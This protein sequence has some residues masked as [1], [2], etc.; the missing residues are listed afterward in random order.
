MTTY[1]GTPDPDTFSGTT[2]RDTFLNIGV[3]D[4]VDGKA[5]DDTIAIDLSAATTAVIYNAVAAATA[6]G[7]NL[8]QGLSVRNV[9]FLRALKTGSGNDTLI[10]S[11]AQGPF[12]WDGNGGTDTLR[13]DFSAATEAMRS[14]VT[15]TGFNFRAGQWDTGD[16][17]TA[18]H[19]ELLYLV[20]SAFND[21][22]AGGAG[23]DTLRGG[24]GDD[25]LNPG[26]GADYVDG[27]DGFDRIAL[28]YATA[29]QNVIYD[30]TVSASA[31][32]GKL[33]NG[34]IVK[35]VE[36]IDGIFT[37]SGDDKL[38]VDAGTLGF[39][40]KAG[41]GFDQLVA[42]YLTASHGITVSNVA[43]SAG[44]LIVITGG[45][46]AVGDS[47]QVLG[48]DR[49]YITGTAFADTLQG[50]K[51]SDRLDG[52]KGVDT[53]AGGLGNDTYIVDSSHDIILEDAG[54]GKDI[55]YAKSNYSLVGTAV[56]YLTLLGTKVINA[57]GNEL[58]NVIKGNTAD[59][60]ITGGL[61]DD[62]MTG[63]DGADTFIFT[64]GSGYDII[65]DFKASQGDMLD[66][67]AYH[68][69]ATAVISQHGATTRIDLGGGN[70]V[71]LHYVTAN[72]EF[73]S[74][75]VW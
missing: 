2:G 42:S 53:L 39:Y 38:I 22:I 69:Q 70:V 5:G 60:R 54:G 35:N 47:G 34:M 56:E 13:I 7:T 46:M 18:N 55:A 20:G 63:G 14:N 61:G 44:P 6:L 1:N 73:L 28:N 49:L 15:A 19:V 57:T 41:A 50:T 23:N 75:I 24:A 48:L 67:N 21:A 45:D 9:E 37:G 64:A 17:A 31:D 36:G 43:T 10:V 68:A 51:G 66:L 72:A 25:V 40:W 8:S 11:V 27:G 3:G 4:T 33:F 52:G 74:H 30:A 62:R 26:G 58:D 65:A 71:E 29:T 12:K 59:N 32:G 16:Y